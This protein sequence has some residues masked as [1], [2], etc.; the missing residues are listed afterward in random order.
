MFI[1][2]A[3]DCRENTDTTDDNTEEVG[4]ADE[5]TDDDNEEYDT[6]DDENDETFLFPSIKDLCDGLETFNAM[7][8]A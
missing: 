3:E 8:I 4:G 5:D 1:Q 6:V 2:P 7:L